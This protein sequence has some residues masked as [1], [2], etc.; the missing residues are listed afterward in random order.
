MSSETS[1]SR[2]ETLLCGEL[3]SRRLYAS[4]QSSTKSTILLLNSLFGAQFHRIHRP[5][6]H[7]FILDADHQLSAESLVGLRKATLNCKDLSQLPAALAQLP[8]SLKVFHLHYA[9]E[10]GN[11]EPSHETTLALGDFLHASTE[12]KYLCLRGHK[13]NFGQLSKGLDL[14]G[15]G[16]L[17]SFR[18][19]GK[20]I[21]TSLPRLNRL[22][23]NH[24]PTQVCHPSLTWLTS[25]HLSRRLTEF[26]HEDERMIAEMIAPLDQLKN[27][28]HFSLCLVDYSVMPKNHWMSIDCENVPGRHLSI[29][30]IVGGNHR[31]W[32]R[33]QPSPRLRSL[34]VR[35]STKRMM[36]SSDDHRRCLCEECVGKFLTEGEGWTGALLLGKRAVHQNLRSIKLDGCRLL[37]TR[38][39][40]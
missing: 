1:M 11:K 7:S 32:I 38:S 22:A 34:S 39:F 26:I 14:S 20:S 40:G 19:M 28:I 36:H 21:P 23:A 27:L 29:H 16:K 24:L 3:L 9:E 31:H 35:C 12:L 5:N 6:F 37:Q 25:L 18:W 33:L 4:L 15:H 2:A 8:K 17:C 30:S 10:L 13:R